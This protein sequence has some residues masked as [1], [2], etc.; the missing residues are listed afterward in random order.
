MAESR[1]RAQRPIL[2]QEELKKKLAVSNFDPNAILRGAQLTV[3]GGEL[4]IREL[5][6][7]CLDLFQ[8]RV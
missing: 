3:V 2:S 4:E 7:Q 5:P 1:S 6:T 8:I